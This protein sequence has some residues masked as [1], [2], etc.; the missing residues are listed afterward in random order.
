MLWGFTAG[1]AP[2]PAKWRLHRG[3]RSTKVVA[4]PRHH[5]ASF[6]A[7]PSTLSTS[8]QGMLPGPGGGSAASVMTA[9]GSR[10]PRLLAWLCHDGAWLPATSA[11]CK[12][13]SAFHVEHPSSRGVWRL[14]N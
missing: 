6:S 4:W 7:C 5:S 2:S 1:A 11:A 13:F 9:L 12:N 10:R 8:T 14:W 3:R